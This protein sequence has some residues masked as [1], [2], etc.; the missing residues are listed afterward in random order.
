M[1]QGLLQLN[2]VL[3]KLEPLHR[4]IGEP[5]GSVLLQ[6]LAASASV[7]DATLSPLATPL[8]HALS[9]AHA[10]ITMFV[11]VCR[12][13]QVSTCDHEDGKNNFDGYE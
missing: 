13:G 6:E 8:L 4:P 10:Y 9:A 11:H 7:P 2:E 12:M 3:Q 1:R 5:G